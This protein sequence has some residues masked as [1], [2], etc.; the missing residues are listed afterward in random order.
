MSLPPLGDR[1]DHAAAAR[2]AR[3]ILPEVS[4][5][6]AISIRFLPGTLGDA[7]LVAYL[8]CRIADTLEDDGSATPERKAELLHTF[9]RALD[10][11]Q[12]AD[13]FP[14][15]AA[16]I[17]GDAGHLR[18]LARTDAVLLLFR[19]LPPR[20]RERV[21]HW[22][23]EMGN[24]MAKFVRLHPTGIRIQTVEEY[25]EYC[26][27]V[28][29]TVGCMLTDLW[30]EHGPGI[31]NREHARLWEKC[32]QFGE[33]LQTVNILKDIAWDAEHENSI[34]IPERSLTEHGSSHATLLASD[35]QDGSHAAVRSFIALAARDLD[36][37][38]EYITLLPWRAFR[39]RAFCVL[40]LLFAYATLRDLTRS[41]AML[42]PGG[43]VKISRA[44]VRSLMIVG[45]LSLGSNAWLR[46]LVRR[47]QQG[48]VVFFAPAAG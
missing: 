33:A 2:W 27:Y 13:R 14:A 48:P 3:A 9:L 26:Y 32:Q 42:E 7:V 19:A 44:E 22:V 21:A 31:G 17:R 46:R 34:Y 15:L 28:A 5:T 4:R 18:L 39:I 23:R 45:V 47:V 8:L 6:F 29:G 41:R 36:D 24:G 25:R 10:D 12:L 37:A 40:P 35:H 11:P 1:P 38:L 43:V 16:D 20:T 30:R